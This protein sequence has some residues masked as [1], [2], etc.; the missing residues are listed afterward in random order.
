MSLMLKEFGHLSMTVAVCQAIVRQELSSVD[1]KM[2]PSDEK[3]H[4]FSDTLLADWE[5]PADFLSIGK[6]DL[7]F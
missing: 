3:L 4:V 5:I 7:F 1:A 6:L 2:R